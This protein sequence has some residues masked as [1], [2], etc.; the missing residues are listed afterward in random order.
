MAQPPLRL[1]TAGWSI[2]RAVAGGFPAEGS[3]LARY[4]AR[5]DAAEINSSFYRPHKPATYARWAETVPDGFRF[6]VKVPKTI[7]HERRLVDVEA[8][9]DRFLTEVAALGPK[10]GPLLVQLPPSLRFEAE[11]ADA[12]LI[13]LRARAVE[14]AVACE[15]RHASWFAP[16]ADAL[17]AAHRV[18][19]VAADPAPVPETAQ[20]G[21]WP[22]LVYHRLHG[23]PRMYWSPYEPPALDA[24]AA[25]F[26]A[27]T[28][29]TWC[30]FDNTASGAAAANA[31]DLAA[32]MTPHRPRDR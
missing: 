18:A 7:T 31:F 26:A 27:R 3:G 23:A 30:M 16:E 6:A 19:R 24:L 17:L 25:G 32:R 11:V 1:G 12:F 14:A 21:G 2:P 5:F 4:A 22:G 28:A 10:L 13:A 20:P 9:L 29:E 8:P 15:P